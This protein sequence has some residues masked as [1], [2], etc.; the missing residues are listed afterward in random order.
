M[1]QTWCLLHS[2]T[3]FLYFFSHKTKYEYFHNLSQFSAL[4]EDFMKCNRI[5]L[6]QQQFFLSRIAQIYRRSLSRKFFNKKQSNNFSFS[7]NLGRK[8][9]NQS[10]CEKKIW[11]YGEMGEKNSAMP[12]Q[13]GCSNNNAF[14]HTWKLMVKVVLLFTMKILFLLYII[15]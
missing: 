3:L 6:S 13:Q 10:K 14:S 8:F 2:W 5:F 15:A 4:V 7:F 11:I 12:S 9:I 1:K